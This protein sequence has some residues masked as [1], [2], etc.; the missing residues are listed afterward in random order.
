MPNL[1]DIKRRITSVTNTQQ[2]TRAMKLVAAAKLRRA[3]DAVTAA[4]PYAEKVMEV[5]E[6]LSMRVDPQAHPMLTRREVKNILILVMSGDKGLCGPFNSNVFKAAVEILDE[7]EDKGISIIVVGKKGVDF[8]RRRPYAVVDQFLEYGK[9]LDISLAQKIAEVVATMFM[10][11][12]VDQVY[13]VYNKFKNVVV[14]EP[15]TVSLLPT[16]LPSVEEEKRP[17]D[18]EYEPS[19]EVALDGMLKRYMEN[20]IFQALL[21]SAASE[22]GSRMTAM[23]AATKN[24]KEMIEGLTLV[25]NRARQA[26]ITTELIEV[27]TGADALEG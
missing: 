3:Q 26:A 18:Y 17:V 12:K 4:R 23:D 9:N 13:M 22:N 24:A 15:Q 14:Q 2:I 1:K 5:M 16:A 10:E 27:V 25:Y 21:E 20:Q 7:N 19:A 11:E 6:S 8:F